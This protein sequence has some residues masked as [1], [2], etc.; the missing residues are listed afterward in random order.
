MI[1][2]VSR[3]ALWAGVV[4]LLGALL[5]HHWQI[6]VAPVPLDLYEGTMPLITGIIADGHNPF[7]RPFQPQAADVY[8]PLYNLLVAPLSLVFG[9]TFQLHRGVSAIFILA[10]SGLCGLAAHRYCRSALYGATAAVL[11]YAALLFYATPVSSTN[12][13]GVALFLAGLLVPWLCRFSDRSLLFALACGLLAFYTKQYFIL[14]TAILC[15]Y[16]FL[17]VSMSR[18]LL[19]GTAFAFALVSTLAAV[20]LA[21]PYYLDNTL[22]APA[23]AIHGL[24]TWEILGMQL[25]FYLVVYGGLL[26]AVAVCLAMARRGARRAAPPGGVRDYFRPAGRGWRGPLME[27]PVDFFWFALFWASLAIV[28]WLGRNPGN[29][30]TYLFQLMSPFL[31]LAGLGAVARPGAPRWLVTPLLLFTAFQAWDILHKDF[32]VDLES[33]RRVEHM[34]AQ[35]D[36]V[37]ATQMLV[38]S[39]LRQ[40]RTVHQ[41]GHTFYFPLAVH[42]PRWLVKARPEDRVEAVWRDYMTDLYRKVERREFDLILVSPWEMRGI[43][44]RNPPPFEAVGG[45]AFLARHYFLD[46]KIPLSMTD[47]HGAGT[48]DIQVWRPKGE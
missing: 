43:F 46:E 5:Y 34:I 14:G 8:P 23:A 47:R 38:M 1:D 29:W 40:G 42:K 22:F 25:R 31:L 12:A 9:N 15:L 7:T 37:L 4:A 27:R 17:Y 16:L 36:E 10:A 44:R 28:L 45:Q 39:L 33:W 6:L 48:Y 41:D 19:L 20:H 3:A 24:Q 30:M 21:S 2:T 11:L 35:S 26:V 13:P 18:A 32:S